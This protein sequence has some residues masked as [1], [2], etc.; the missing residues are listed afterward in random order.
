MGERQA[1]DPNAMPLADFIS[2]VM[3]ILAT[4]PEANEILV[5]RV[6]PLRFA[7]D[8]DAKQFESFFEQFNAAIFQ[9]MLYS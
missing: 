1:N 3:H 9:R 4:Q 2:E 6:Y 7:G 8:L 5:E